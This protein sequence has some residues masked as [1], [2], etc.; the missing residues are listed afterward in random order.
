MILNDSPL[1]IEDVCK[2][3]PNIDRETLITA[4]LLFPLGEQTVKRVQLGEDFRRSLQTER[5]STPYRLHSVISACK[6]GKIDGT[7]LEAKFFRHGGA[8][9]T[10][11]ES[12]LHK[13]EKRQGRAGRGAARALHGHLE[14]GR[15]HWW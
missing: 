5:Q 6:E 10:A 15:R 11:L 14:G 1:D 13:R 12:T 8:R 3:Q 4:L 9:A 2:T 7:S